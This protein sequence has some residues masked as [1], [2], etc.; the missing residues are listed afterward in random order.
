[1]KRAYRGPL[2]YPLLALSLA[3]CLLALGGCKDHKAATASSGQM[4]ESVGIA[5]GAFQNELLTYAVDNLNR[6]EEFESSEVVGQIFERLRPKDAA[7]A[8][9]VA[10]LDP[11]AATWPQSEMLATG[12]QPA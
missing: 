7:A 9:E 1:M 10:R 4:K 8:A 3:G 11:L 12:R 5:S 2:L 6:L